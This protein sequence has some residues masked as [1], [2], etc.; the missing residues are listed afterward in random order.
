MEISATARL[1][2][3]RLSHW[4]SQG[5]A[6]ADVYEQLAH[7]D[8]LPAFFDPSDIAAIEGVQPDAVKKARHRG[9]GAAY[10]RM[11]AKIIKYPR[12]DYC[13][14]LGTKYVSRSAG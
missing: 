7:D 8:E 9:T 1:F 3:A 11:S 12:A 13:R 4:T 5:F 14:H 10:L 6:G 2:N